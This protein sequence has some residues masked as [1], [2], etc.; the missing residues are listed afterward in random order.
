MLD[1]NVSFKEVGAGTRLGASVYMLSQIPERLIMSIISI[2]KMAL[3]GALTALTFGKFP[4]FSYETQM[5]Y[6][7]TC[8][9]LGSLFL[10]I[11]SIL[12][13]LNSSNLMH[14]LN[15]W[16]FDR[17][18]QKTKDGCKDDEGYNFYMNKNIL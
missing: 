6:Y 11:T 4:V 18:D 13:P 12:F 3:F 16:C 2:A 9:N 10:C 14:N 5:S 1:L 15:R 7:K 8:N 17:I